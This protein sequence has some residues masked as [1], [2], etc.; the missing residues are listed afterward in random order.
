MNLNNRNNILTLGAALVA[1]GAMLP[2][3][4]SA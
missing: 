2:G 3:A 4:A 1:T